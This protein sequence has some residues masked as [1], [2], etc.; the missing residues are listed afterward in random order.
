[1]E[2]RECC[3]IS[4]DS[5]VVHRLAAGDVFHLAEQVAPDALQ[6]IA[7]VAVRDVSMRGG[8]LRK[9]TVGLVRTLSVRGH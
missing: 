4:R 8:A 3:P 1:M 9:L 2:T 5:C 7:D 6:A